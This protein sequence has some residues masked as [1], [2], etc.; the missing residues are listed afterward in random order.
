MSTAVFGTRCF[1]WNL[2]HRGL[3]RL[4]IQ[5]ISPIL[6]Y[7]TIFHLLTYPTMPHL[8]S[9]LLLCNNTVLYLLACMLQYVQS[10]TLFG[11]NNMYAPI[12]LS[13]TLTM[14]APSDDAVLNFI[15]K[16]NHLRPYIYS[17]QLLLL[18]V[19]FKSV[20]IVSF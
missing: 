18:M 12:F 14:P 20:C 1:P 6:P 10:K 2:I 16:S 11:Q 15:F 19:I 13:P 7:L 4:Q 3:R 9:I 5:N 8:Y 17:K